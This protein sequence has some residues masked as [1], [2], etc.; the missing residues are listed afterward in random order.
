MNKTDSKID[1]ND[2][3][4]FQSHY[5]SI[6]YEIRIDGLRIFQAILSKE[7]PPEQYNGIVNVEY[8]IVCENATSDEIGSALVIN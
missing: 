1:I 8:A 2:I 7:L 3:R 5:Q 6:G 4:N